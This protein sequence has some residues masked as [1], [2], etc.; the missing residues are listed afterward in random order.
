MDT[1]G[2][3]AS[4]RRL[5]DALKREGLLTLREL[6]AAL[7]LSRETLREHVNALAAAGLVRR[8]GNRR[9]GRGRPEV[10]Y[11]L[12]A[13]AEGLFPQKDGQLL[14]ELTAWLTDEGHEA[15]IRAFFE[16]RAERRGA[17]ALSRVEGLRG[18]RRLEEVAKILTEEGYMAEVT[19]R[20]LRLCHC[21]IRQAVDVTRAPCRSELLMVERLL[22]RRLERTDYLPDGGVSCTY[23]VEDAPAR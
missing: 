16:Q 1:P 20:S 9:G 2:L 22:G 8:A 17:D 21:P 11:Q 6:A 18:K 12:T 19:G 10:L 3:G 7:A 15:T 5:L 13:A 4:Q 14:A 23:R